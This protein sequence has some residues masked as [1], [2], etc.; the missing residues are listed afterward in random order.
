MT[1]L[2]SKA[3]LFT[4]LMNVSWWMVKWKKKKFR[5]LFGALHFPG[6]IIGV[7]S[8]IWTEYLP[9]WA[10]QCYHYINPLA[11]QWPTVVYRS[12]FTPSIRCSLVTR[13]FH[14]VAPS[15]SALYLPRRLVN[16]SFI[17]AL[18]V[19]CVKHMY[20]AISHLVTSFIVKC[21]TV[22]PAKYVRS[23]KGRLPEHWIAKFL[24]LTYTH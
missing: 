3:K 8:G 15:G 23:F 14:S 17:Q 24:W 4:Q 7:P 10:L 2:V 1:L 9:I 19:D 22:N 11:L 12:N 5:G 21:E 13:L 6:Q 18:L 20:S 16:L